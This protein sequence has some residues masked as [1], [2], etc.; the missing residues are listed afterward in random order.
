MNKLFSNRIGGCLVLAAAIFQLLPA[1]SFADIPGLR[2]PANEKDDGDVFSV[3][4][5]PYGLSYGEW[6][7]RWWQWAFSL[8]LRRHPLFDTA[9]CNTGQSGPVWFLGGTSEQGPRTRTCTVPAGT[10]LFFPLITPEC[11]DLEGNGTT[12]AKLRA[13]A[14]AGGNLILTDPRH[15]YATLDGEELRKLKQHRVQSPLFEF[16]P[17]PQKNYIQ[18]FGCSGPETCPEP[19]KTPG[20]TGISV[21][22]G[23]WLMLKPLSPGRHTLHFHAELDLSGFGAPNFVEDIT[24]YLTVRR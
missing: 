4:S 15:L 18:F 24:Y 17:L 8:D 20:I 10:A 21:S 1:V 22:D 13:C 7:A 11:S 14:M 2:S 5:D 23:I 19:S 16:G 12:D 3:R 6:S 9:D